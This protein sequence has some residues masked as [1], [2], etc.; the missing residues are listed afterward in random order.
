LNLDETVSVGNNLKSLFVAFLRMN[1]P[2]L[3]I[4]LLYFASNGAQYPWQLY[5]TDYM[6]MDVYKGDPQAPPHT[7]AHANYSLGVRMGSLAMGLMGVSTFITS[8]AVAPAVKLIGYKAVYFIAH[9]WGA[10]SIILPLW[11]LMSTPFA[12]IALCACGGVFNA[13]TTAIPFTL[14]GLAVPEEQVG[15]YVGVLNVVQVLSQII[16]GAVAGAIMTAAAPWGLGSV[17]PGISFAG[18]LTILGL[19]LIFLLIIPLSQAERK[20][21]A[22]IDAGSVN[23]DEKVPFSKS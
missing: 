23:V 3:R 1:Q 20:K 9:L 13:I 14:I 8:F 2:T 21:E 6:G 7:Q 17:A 19:P 22:Q 18:M 12:A 4:V 15:V 10:V 5:F 11:P 16:M